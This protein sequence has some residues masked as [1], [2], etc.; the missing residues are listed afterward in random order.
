MLEKTA[1]SM[2]EKAPSLYN[3][4][5]KILLLPSL[6]PENFSEVL[7]EFPQKV[8]ENLCRGSPKTSLK[9]FQKFP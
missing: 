3:K 9:Y 8:L 6:F 1:G 7:V 5:R 2:I 4:Q